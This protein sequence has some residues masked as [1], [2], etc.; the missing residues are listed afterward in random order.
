MLTKWDGRTAW[1]QPGLPLAAFWKN[2]LAL[3]F[4]D[5]LPEGH[6]PGGDSR[7]IEVMREL[8][9]QPDSPWWDD[10]TTPDQV[11]SRDDIL[12]QSFAGGGEP[13]G[14]AEPSNGLGRPAHM[15]CATAPG[16]SG[17]HRALFNRGPYRTAGGEAIV[18]ATGWDPNAEDPY[19]VN[20]LPAHRM[21]VDLNDLDSSTTIHTSGQSGHA[22]HKHYDDMVDLWRNL[23]SHAM[24]WE[25]S[26]IETEAEGHLRLAP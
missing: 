19:A 13:G 14:W 23:Q 5:D 26:R 22:Y 8:I 4:N 20:W 1:I 10:Q 6:A 25:R 7:W 11:E 17:A 24:L 15:T 12:L 3:T 16:R 2:L 21:V 9:K 18:N